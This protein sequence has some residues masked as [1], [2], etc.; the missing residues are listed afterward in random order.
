MLN[1]QHRVWRPG[2][3]KAH[4]NPDGGYVYRHIESWRLCVGDL[5]V[6]RV[7]FAPVRQPAYDCHPIVWR[8]LRAALKQKE[9]LNE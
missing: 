4:D 5:R 8:Q 2:K 7:P 6:C 1:V 3:L 9:L